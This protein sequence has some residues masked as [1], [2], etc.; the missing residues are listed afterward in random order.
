MNREEA[1]VRMQEIQRIMERA[2]LWTLLPGAAAVMGGRLVLG[3]CAV[4]YAMLR[5]LDFADILK[6]PVRHK[7]ASA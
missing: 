5:S 2:T 6:L 7:S 3:G 4:S 1:Q